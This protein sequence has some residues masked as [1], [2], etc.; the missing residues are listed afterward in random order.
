MDQLQIITAVKAELDRVGQDFA[1]DELAYLA[2]TSKVELPIR[3]RL[4]FRLFL[5]FK[6]TPDLCVAREWKRFDLAILDVGKPSVILEAKAM[7]SFDM[8]TSKAE[9]QYPCAIH[10]DVLNFH[11]YT[12]RTQL[13]IHPQLVTLLLATHPYSP[14]SRSLDGIVKYNA[15]V[16]SCAPPSVEAL[17]DRVES[18]FSDHPRLQLGEIAAGRA[19]GV[20]VSVFYWLFGPY[21]DAA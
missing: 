16:H 18:F 2:L 13:S 21:P 6:S 1:T 19:F 4:A 10:K 17:L 11:E 3:D 5:A 15:Q 9:A 7:Y 20:D 14:P 12:E 8:F